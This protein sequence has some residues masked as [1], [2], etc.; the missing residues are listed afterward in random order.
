MTAR[1]AALLALVV[2]LGLGLGLGLAGCVDGLTP[3]VGPPLRELCAD[4]DSDPSTAISYQHDVVMGIFSRPDVHCIKCHTAGGDSPIGLLVG[5]LDLGSYDG[6]RHG[7]A[8]SGA[9]VVIPGQPCESMLYR[10]V[11]NGPPFGAR[12]PL[13]GPPFLSEDD[14]QVIVDWIAEGARDN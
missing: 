12:M 4:V 14:V 7:G 5:G 10:K 11:E 6:L 13:D 9:D 1:A 3:D 2:E 8:Q